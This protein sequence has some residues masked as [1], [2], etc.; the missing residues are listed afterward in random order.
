MRLAMRDEARFSARH[1]RRVLREE[2]EGLH[3][4]QPLLVFDN[5]DKVRS[6]DRFGDGAHDEAI[7]RVVAAILYTARGTA[8][9]Y[10]GAEIGMRTTPP[11]RVEDVKD[12]IG[13]TGWPKE[14]GRDGERTPMQWTAGAQAGFSSSTRPWLPVPAGHDRINVERELADPGSLLRWTMTLTALRHSEPSLSGPGAMQFVDADDPD[15]LA[16][17]RSAPAGGTGDGLAQGRVFVAMNLSA[18]PRAFEAAMPALRAPGPVRVLAATHP[19]LG[20]LDTLRRITLPPFS[21]VIASF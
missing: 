21:V 17:V 3:G 15:V 5:H 8:L 9:T 19:A 13:I 2:Q 18:S 11:T 6:I 12:P 4:S 14:K 7:A 20:S 16:F 10:Y 1:F